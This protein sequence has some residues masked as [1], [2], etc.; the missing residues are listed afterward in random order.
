MLTIDGQR[1]VQMIDPNDHARRRFQSEE[2]EM[3]SPTRYNPTNCVIC[4]SVGI[5]TPAQIEIIRDRDRDGLGTARVYACDWCIEAG[6]AED[7]VAMGIT[8]DEWRWARWRRM[9]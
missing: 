8:A 1:T 5:Q 9:R 2:D 3:T 7:R 4:A 6:T